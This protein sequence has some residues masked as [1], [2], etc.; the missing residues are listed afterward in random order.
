MRITSEVLVKTNRLIQLAVLT[1]LILAVANPGFA[2]QKGPDLPPDHPEVY[3]SFFMFM[4][5]FGQWL[6]N[7]A[8]KNPAH[9]AVLNQSAARYLNVDVKELPSLIDY[10]RMSAAA[11]RTAEDGHRTGVSGGIR[12]AAGADP[13]LR[14]ALIANRQAAIQSATDG[15]RRLLSAKSW[16]GLSAHINVEH[17][18]HISV[19][20]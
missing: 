18:R 11:I 12:S 9:A 4:D 14:E 1:V 13:S 5:N 2:Q 10:C 20:R 19:N 17:R 15:L 8:E 7:E 3:Y 6:A 16:S